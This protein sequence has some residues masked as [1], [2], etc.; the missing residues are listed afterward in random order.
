[1]HDTRRTRLVLSVLLIAAIGL[2]TISFRDGN[3]SPVRG[4][5]GAGAGVFGPVERVVGDVTRPITGFFGAITG[6]PS[7]NGKI[8]ALQ[9][10]NSQLR[11]QLATTQLGRAEEAQLSKL[12]QLAGRG[13][14]RIVAANVIAVGQDYDDTVTLDVGSRDGIKPDET[15]LNGDGLVGTVTRVSSDT[16]TVLLETDASAVVGA[17]LAGSGQVGAVTGTGKSFPGGNV[18]RLQLFD[19][20]TVLQA[21]ERLVTF[22]S[23]GGQPY[24]AGVP[25]GEITQVQGSAN[26]LTK[27][28]LVRPFVDFTSLGVVG[29]VV[30]PPRRD[31]RDSVLPP[32]PHP[33]PTVTVTV[34]P[35]GTPGATPTTSA[36]TGG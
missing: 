33:A 34:T 10:Q 24:V 3:S 36:R 17:R 7:A 6:A 22:G 5:G 1:V 9:R 4:L 15:V 12:L 16:S 25:I 14:Y 31:P 20:N 21:G 32:R 18:L 2:I 23:V 35:Q 11:A 27:L 26:A 29:V 30:I 28:A 8:A 19:A 13:G